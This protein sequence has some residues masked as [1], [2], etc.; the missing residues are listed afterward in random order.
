M[1]DPSVNPNPRQIQGHYPQ[2]DNGGQAIL[3]V[4]PEEWGNFRFI[5]LVVPDSTPTPLFDCVALDPSDEASGL[6]VDKTME[7]VEFMIINYNTDVCCWWGDMD[8]EPG[9]GLPIAE[10]VDNGADPSDPSPN[11]FCNSPGFAR[12]RVDPT[13]VYL[14]QESGGDINLTLLFVGRNINAG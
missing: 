5:P 10:A 4:L 3:D 13:K 9:L 12:L 14:Y 6:P 8:V 1:A 11:P 7:L 2:S